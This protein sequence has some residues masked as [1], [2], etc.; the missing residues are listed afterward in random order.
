MR[1]NLRPVLRREEF[2]DG[3]AG[4]LLGAAPG[5]Q[6]EVVVP[7][8]E[9]AVG[10]D[11]VEDTGDRLQDGLAH[12]PLLGRRLLGS[13]AQGDVVPQGGDQPAATHG[14]GAAADPDVARAAVPAA[15]P[16]LEIAAA[17]TA[18]A[19]HHRGQAVGVVG[20]LHVAQVQGREL[21]ARVAQLGAGGVV[22][23]DEAVVLRVEQHD[24]VGG[25]VDDGAV[26]LLAVA[27]RLLG[28][29]LGRDVARDAQ[30]ADEAA[31]GHAHRRLDGLE[32]APVAVA[33]EGQ[34]FL[35]DAR[36]RGFQRQAVV[37]AEEVGQLAA[38]EGV[39]VL[40]HDVGLGVAKELL[41]AGVASQVQAPRVLEPHQVGDGM[42]Q[43]GQQGM[44]IVAVVQRLAPGG[45][46]AHDQ[47][48]GQEAARHPA[49]QAQ[50]AAQAPER[51]A[52]GRG[53]GRRHDGAGM[54][55]A[56]ADQSP[57]SIAMMRL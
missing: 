38:G 4:Q 42:H 24:A 2:G 7:E 57:A 50:A 17:R 8:G 11:G 41:E 56:A 54:A 45:L 30:H 27:Q 37:G 53:L 39:V 25:V 47:G 31:V 13:L 28:G 20:V 10:V 33:G 36:C 35:V 19:R 1:A 40:A 48:P 18:Q 6:P 34:P 43:A 46:H 9:L 3:Q 51:A 21:A 23:F 32:Q 49:R 22:E 52:R 55:M 29:A 5:G 44:L 15:M 14:D 12:L 16:V 26:H